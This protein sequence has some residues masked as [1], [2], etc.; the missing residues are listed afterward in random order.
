MIQSYLGEV[1]HGYCADRI[2]FGHRHRRLS[3]LDKTQC[4]QV[5]GNSSISSGDRPY[6]RLT[7]LL[8]RFVLMLSS[9]LQSDLL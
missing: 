8:T 7:I 6:M 2:P 5:A 9:L 4:M 1:S 3:I